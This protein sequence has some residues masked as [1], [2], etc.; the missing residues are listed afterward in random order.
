M[1]SA[2]HRSRL[3][4]VGLTLL[5]VVVLVAVFAPLLSSHDPKA[6]SGP[7][8]ESPSARHWLGTDNPGHDIFTQ[9]VFGARVSLAVG[10]IA[11]SLTMLAAILVGVLPALTGGF[12]DRSASRAVVV[13]LALPG[14]PLIVLIGSL[15]G[16]SRLSV[17]SVIAFIGIAP[18]ARILRAQALTLRQR[19]YITAA[20]GFGGGPMYVL[21]RHLVPGLAPLVV[22]GFVNWAGLAIGLEAGL[23][24]L[25]VGDPTGVSW[26][27]MLN[28]ALNEQ[29]IYFSGMWTWWV[30][31]PGLAIALTVLGFTFVG[32]GL[33]PT[34]NPRWLRAT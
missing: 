28:R 6:I 23:A 14:L 17:I 5:G 18:N 4:H 34:F 15:A 9:A 19:G 26:G 11:G 22:V 10:F 24:F 7:A 16:D 31:P 13:L 27:L 21:R 12:A 32:V 20:R 1:S 30:L 25:G 2:T 29:S 8:L 33:E 3:L